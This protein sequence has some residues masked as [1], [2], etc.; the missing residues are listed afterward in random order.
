MPLSSEV[1]PGR[2]QVWSA[3]SRPWLQP[4]GVWGGKACSSWQGIPCLAHPGNPA[5]V[6]D[7]GLGSHLDFSWELL[8]EQPPLRLL[9]DVSVT[10]LLSPVW[11]GLYPRA[12][13]CPVSLG[14]VEGSGLPLP[15]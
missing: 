11:T 5:V 1:A 6:A 2:L 9:T 8:Q 7:Q 15:E 10:T 4:G 13:L 12:R 3:A 14:Q